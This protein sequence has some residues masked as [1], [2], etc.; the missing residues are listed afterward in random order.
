MAGYRPKSA[1]PVSGYRPR[2]AQPVAEPRAQPEPQEPGLFDPGTLSEALVPGLAQAR[3]AKRIF[4]GDTTPEDFSPRDLARLRAL[5]QGATIFTG[6]EAGGV[7]QAVEPGTAADFAI[8]GLRALRELAQRSVGRPVGEEIG[9]AG[10]EADRKGE[11]FWERYRSV[12]DRDRAANVAAEEAYPTDYG[13]FQFLGGLPATVA[14]PGYAGAALI[15]GAAGLGGGE[16]DLTRGDVAGAALETGAGAAMGAAGQALGKGVGKVVGA[17]AKPL[18]SALRKFGA[19]RALSA[20]GT[21]RA[22]RMKLARGGQLEQAG[23]FLLDEGVVT[24]GASLEKVAE[25]LARI[26]DATGKEIGDLIERFQ[27]AQRAMASDFT[28]AGAPPLT[29]DALDEI[30]AAMPRAPTARA[31]ATTAVGRLRQAAQ[32]PRAGP[33]TVVERGAAQRTQAGYPRFPRPEVPEAEQ[34]TK[35]ARFAALSRGPLKETAPPRRATTGEGTQILPRQRAAQVLERAEKTGVHPERVATE[36][37]RAGN[38]GR[39]G[40]PTQVQPT[41][42]EG[43]PAASPVQRLREAGRGGPTVYA[44]PQPVGKAPAAPELTGGELKA[45][46]TAE[47]DR[48]RGLPG[49]EDEGRALRRFAA[50]IQEGPMSI[51]RAAQVMRSF[52]KPAK[53]DV[54]TP[55]AVASAAQTAR[56]QAREYIQEHLLRLADQGAERGL[57]RN[58]V[59]QLRDANVRFGLSAELGQQAAERIPGWGANLPFGL[60][61]LILAGGGAAAGAAAGGDVQSAL[62]GAGLGL[63]TKLV[64]TYGSSVAAPMLQALGRGV[65]RGG[66]ATSAAS[67]AVARALALA[68]ALRRREEEP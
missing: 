38:V 42:V 2:S 27:G 12:R 53:F 64:R 10:R 48:L 55:G 19:G 49:L 9:G 32:A 21:M 17:V 29:L 24:P 47:A 22:G 1:V 30:A 66:A 28:Q 58:L 56:Q 46:M 13:V 35:A 25:R 5:A 11:G 57:D 4:T 50:R 6:E 40:P 62:K 8:P 54:R 18:G 16:A 63:G 36:V 37:G 7:L 52:D 67:P 59:Q 60:P 68:E 51:Q 39:A 20:A 44:K 26:Q 61:E 45:R 43:S 3:K 33:G 34:A 65:A 31:G 23:Q 15:G 14:A 41:R